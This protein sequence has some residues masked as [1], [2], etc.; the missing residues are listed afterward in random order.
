MRDALASVTAEQFP[1]LFALKQLLLTGDGESRGA[2]ALDVMIDGMLGDRAK[3][4]LVA[5]E[6]K[7][8]GRKSKT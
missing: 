1:L 3:P 7:T 5:S 6:P 4:A 2:W 8:R